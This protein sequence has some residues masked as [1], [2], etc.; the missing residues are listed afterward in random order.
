VS[1]LGDLLLA[2]H[3]SLERA[4][5]PHAIGGAIALG[6]CTLEPRGT[7]DLDV[8]VFLGP[9]R[10][11]DVLGALP[12]Q[13][14]FDGSRLEQ[15]ERDGQTRLRS[16]P[17][18]V[19]IFLSV[20]A[21]H[22]DVAAHVREVPFEGRTIPVLGCTGLAV[23]K[24]MFAR[25]QDWVDIERMVEARTIDLD[26]AIGWVIEMTGAESQEAARLVALRDHAGAA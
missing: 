8:N 25:P 22:D 18:P 6:Y 23:F 24:A 19:D 17:T 1:E 7:R 20:L 4:R 16:G 26:D 21:F 5:I 2:V 15:L 10:A 12:P 9:E 13:V 3:D 11:K 14:E